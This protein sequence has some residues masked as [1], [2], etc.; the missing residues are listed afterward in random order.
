MRYQGWTQGTPQRSR[1]RRPDAIRYRGAVPYSWI[2]FLHIAAAIGFVGI[3]GASIVV[4]YAIRNQTDRNRIEGVLDFSSSTA[5]AMYVSMV[6]VIGTG[7]WMGFVRTSLFSQGWYWWSLALLVVT[8][9]VMLLVA[10]P[11]TMR[12]RAATEVRPSG[13]PRVSDEELAQTLRS[14]RAHVITAIGVVGLSAILYLMVFQPSL[15]LGSS[16][17][18][19]PETPTTSETTLPTSGSTTSA[20]GTTPEE[21]VATTAPSLRDA[22][23]LAMGKQLYDEIAGGRGCA[24]CHGLDGHGSG[25]APNIIG[26]SKSAISESLGGG[27]PDMD[28]IRLSGYELEAVYQYVKTLR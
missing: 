4:L 23:M 24:E 19:E 13:V 21:S 8:S 15:S 6:A 14:P 9:V 1:R 28:S 16:E 11:F 17:A 26:V 12:V 18:A 10:K 5:T 3:H 20:A 25:D 27:V 7:I 2:R 22:A